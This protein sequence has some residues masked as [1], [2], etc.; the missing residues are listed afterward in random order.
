MQFLVNSNIRHMV[1][2]PPSEDNCFF[3][4]DKHRNWHTYRPVYHYRHNCRTQRWGFRRTQQSRCTSDCTPVPQSYHNHHRELRLPHPKP[5]QTDSSSRR[6]EEVTDNGVHR[7]E[8]HTC[9]TRNRYNRCFY[10][11]TRN[12]HNRRLY[13]SGAGCC[14]SSWSFPFWSPSRLKWQRN[15]G[16]QGG[17]VGSTCL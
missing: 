2:Q 11:S 9:S 7:K 17:V 15:R 5:P 3:C 16:E 1:Q 8:V 10:N 12:R 4:I 13:N 14:V 6:L